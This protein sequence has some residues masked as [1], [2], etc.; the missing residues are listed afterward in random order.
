[1]T[2]EDTVTLPDGTVVDV[3]IPAYHVPRSTGLLLR[4]GT[5]PVTVRLGFDFD[6]WGFLRF[7]DVRNPA[8]PVEIARFATANSQNPAVADEGWFTAHNPEVRGNRLYA[9]WYADGVRLLE[10]TAPAF[11]RE[12]GYWTGLGAP[13]DAPPVDIWSVVPHRGVLLASDRNYGLYVLRD[14]YL[15]PGR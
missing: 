15:R 2:G 4:D 5:A 14:T 10:I 1:M 9:S 6:G 12:V 3:A 8:A 13:A 7:Y 11:P